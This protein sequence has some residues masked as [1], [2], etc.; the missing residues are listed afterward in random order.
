MR[1]SEG[2]RAKAS[3]RVLWMNKSLSNKE[4]GTASQAENQCRQRH[5]LPMQ[6]VPGREGKVRP[7]GRRVGGK[8]ITEITG[9]DGRSPSSKAVTDGWRDCQIT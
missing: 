6:A 7:E 3:H 8:G 9:G 4:Q 1:A 5:C 2:S